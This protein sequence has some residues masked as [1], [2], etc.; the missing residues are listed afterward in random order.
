M[1]IQLGATSINGMYLGAT[2]ILTAYL[3]DTLV[4]G[5]GEDWDTHADGRFYDVGFNG[6]ASLIG[7]Y[8]D[9]ST[10]YASTAAANLGVLRGGGS[11]LTI[12]YWNAATDTVAPYAALYSHTTGQWLGWAGTATQPASGTYPAVYDQPGYNAVLDTATANFC[13]GGSTICTV[14]MLSQAPTNF[15]AWTAPSIADVPA[16]PLQA[17]TWTMQTSSSASSVVSS[18]LEIIKS[19]QTTTLRDLPG[20]RFWNGTE[21]DNYGA[22]AGV[23][24]SGALCKAWWEDNYQARIRQNGGVWITMD[25]STAGTMYVGG[26]SYL[27]NRIGWGPW[28]SPDWITQAGGQV[29]DI[30]V[31]AK[32]ELP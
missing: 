14:V 25:G 10:A 24:A 22:T 8:V 26:S 17:I 32:G 1:S 5:G 31:Y 21:A 11:I 7:A 15:A 4:F 28:A 12:R 29:I 16:E 2:S 18:G 30:E 9:P 23:F 19:T 3:G 13:P 6:T 27:Y 20:P